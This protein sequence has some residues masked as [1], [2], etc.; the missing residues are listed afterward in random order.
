MKI[1]KHMDGWDVLF[2]VVALVSLII[3]AFQSG[4]MD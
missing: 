1:F 3:F 2:I 4:L